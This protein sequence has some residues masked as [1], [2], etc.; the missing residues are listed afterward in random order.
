MRSK[1]FY[2]RGLL[3]MVV[4]AAALVAFTWGIHRDWRSWWVPAAFGIAIAALMEAMRMF[5]RYEEARRN[6]E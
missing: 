1:K 5:G 3:Y 6:G 2:R 4:L